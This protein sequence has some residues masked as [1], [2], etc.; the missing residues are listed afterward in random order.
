MTETAQKIGMSSAAFRNASGLPR[1]GHRV[2]VQ[3]L[4][5]LAA[6]IQAE[7]PERMPLFA[8]TSI[9]W[10]GLRQ[11]NRNPALS[12][13]LS[14]YGAVADGMKTGHTNAAGYCVV[15]TATQTRKGAP[16]RRFIVVLA[17]LRS[18]AQRARETDRALKWALERG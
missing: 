16:P 2:S 5:L 17:G 6:R 4:A 10:G 9:R 18:E 7:F 8:R 14:R 13:D 12:L 11:W 3:D 15:A 1:K